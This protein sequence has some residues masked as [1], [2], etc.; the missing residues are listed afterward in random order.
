M[1]TANDNGGANVTSLSMRHRM[2]A[3]GA[4]AYIT[5]RRHCMPTNDRFGDAARVELYDELLG[6]EWRYV[7]VAGKR[8]EPGSLRLVIDRHAT[9]AM[10]TVYILGDKGENIHQFEIPDAV[11]TQAVYAY[12]AASDA[13]TRRGIA[14]AIGEVMHNA[15]QE[16]GMDMPHAYAESMFRCCAEQLA[17]AQ[18]Q[19]SRS[20]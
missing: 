19:R 3:T 20:R 16:A 13:Y 12:S 9:P 1:K 4:T 11:I 14:I 10:R 5:A 6:Q 15:A 7:E 18:V 8:Y 17:P 2:G